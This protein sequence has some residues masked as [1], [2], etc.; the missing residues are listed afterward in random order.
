MN[1]TFGLC[2]D[3]FA[4]ADPR[5]RFDE[6]VCGPVG[7][8]R[9]LELRLGLVGALP[10]HGRRV[11]GYRG[12]LAALAA[13][14]PQFY[15]ASFA[16]DDYAVAETLLRWRDELVLAGWDGQAA[17]GFSPR[18]ATLA[19]VEA[20][21]DPALRTGEGDRLRAITSALAN[22]SPQFNECTLTDPPQSL[23]RLWSSAG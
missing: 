19:A 10:S 13:A 20:T 11:V 2:L 18:L 23:P 7:L 12:A 22:R 3:G 16:Q 17:A 1:V 9:L 6:L 21:L 15:S 14:G 5:P 8:L 4:F